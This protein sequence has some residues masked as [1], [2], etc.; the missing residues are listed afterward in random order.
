MRETTGVPSPGT[1]SRARREA[2][3]LPVPD[4]LTHKRT[5]FVLW[6][7]SSSGTPPRLVIGTA[8]PGANGGFDPLADLPMENG[9]GIPDVWDLPAAALGLEDGVYHYW[10]LVEDDDPY[11]AAGGPVHRADPHAYVTDWR[12]K[13]DGA[14]A[15]VIRLRGGALIL[16]DADGSEPALPAD[17]AVDHLPGNAALVLYQVPVAWTR[18]SMPVTAESVGVG[19]YADVRRLVDGRGRGGSFTPPP[20][21]VLDLG[22]NALQLLPVA[23]THQDRSAWGYG[24]SNALAPDF[25]LS[26]DP[27]APLAPARPAGDL[28]EL[29]QAC[30]ENALRVFLDVVMAFS[31]QDPYRSANFLDFHVRWGS[32]DPEQQGRDGFGGDLWKYAWPTSGWDPLT[33]ERETIYPARQHMK[34][35]I[36]HWLARYHADGIRIDSVGNVRNFDFLREFRD[37]AY[38]AWR[39]ARGPGDEDRFLVLGESLPVDKEYLRQG[40]GDALWN[41]EFKTI[42]RKVILGR[43]ADGEPSFE[44]SVR[45]LIEPVH[46]GYGALTTAVNYVGSHDVAG[47]ANERL[48]DYLGFCGVGGDEERA[49]RIRLA[50]ACLLTSVGIP[51]IFAGD[52]FADQHDIP[53]WNLS[54]AERNGRKQTD[55]VNYDRLRDHPW[56][57]ELLR[58]VSRLVKLRT[59]AQALHVRDTNFIHVDFEEGKRVLAWVRGRPLV[60]RPVV[61][62]ANFSSWGSDVSRPGA[63]YVVPNWPAAPGARWVEVTQGREVPREWVGREPLYPW[64]AKVYTT[65]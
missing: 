34:V 57:R 6:R 22:A 13:L 2:P 29:V 24:T 26:F 37:E 14:P 28:M 19:T 9:L 43:N 36:A 55:P 53:I 30:H 54:E 5:H 62:V 17:A 12:V 49:R 35:A 23:D 48:H 60:H 25:D 8:T 1:G 7:P 47:P 64:E 41:E 11:G 51:M 15:S 18:T 4:L 27:A 16:C 32:G 58:Y 50:F 45:K 40:V 46:L 63:E 21:H 38:K 10:F 31:D 59:S 3:A 65:V 39:E 20:R 52:E 61:V 56:R 42:L 33:G 44:W